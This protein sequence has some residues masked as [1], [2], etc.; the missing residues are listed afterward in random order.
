TK[1]VTLNVK[2]VPVEEVV[3]LAL[4]DQPISYII[5]GKT[6]A[7]S[8]KNET[9]KDQK[10]KST[11]ANEK[12]SIDIGGKVV[13]SKGEPISKA[14]VSVKETE[15]ITITNSNGEF[16]FRNINEN[17]ILLITNVGFEPVIVPLNGQNFVRVTLNV[18]VASLE[19]F[20][21]IGYGQVTK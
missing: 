18:R 16:F 12:P 2:N 14:T 8:K 15:V 6:I 3:K 17:A 13:N 7:L 1:P 20:I 19:D 11:S 9:P 4:K 10:G 5:E 21:V